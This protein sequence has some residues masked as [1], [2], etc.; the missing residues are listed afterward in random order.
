MNATL[1]CLRVVP[2]L[3]EALVKYNVP[4]SPAEMMAADNGTPQALTRGKRV[5]LMIYSMVKRLM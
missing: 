3:K 4:A 5:N 1:Q 2:E